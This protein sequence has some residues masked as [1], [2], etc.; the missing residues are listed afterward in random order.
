MSA[1]YIPIEPFEFKL[2][3]RLSRILDRNIRN[4]EEPEKMDEPMNV[5]H[6]DGPLLVAASRKSTLVERRVSLLT[7]LP[8]NIVNTKFF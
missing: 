1:F 6:C 4:L 5:L 8:S 7:C 3:E 2:K